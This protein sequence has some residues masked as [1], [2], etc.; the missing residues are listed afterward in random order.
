[1][2]VYPSG[3]DLSTSTLRYLADLLRARRRERG[4]RWRRLTADRQALLALAH[5]R[6][7][8]TY[9]QLA[10]G[11]GIGLATV[12][13][14][15]V[16]AIEVLAALAPTLQ[17]VITVAAN[18]AFV[19]LDGTLLHIDRIAADRP[20][21]SGKHKR[22][23]MN[24]QVIADAFGRLLW[25]S[26]ALPG[27]VHDIKAARTHGIVEALT[28]AGIRTWADKGYQGAQGTIRVPYQG[29]WRTLP[30]GKRAVNSSHARIRAVGEQ[31]NA[32]RKSWR[33]LRKL[34]CS[35]TRITDIVKAVLAL[36]LATA[37]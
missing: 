10:V 36:H 37:A 26:P 29:R 24:V 32:T 18:K 6:G 20:Y 30:A 7:G 1:M 35:T 22:H 27:A 15:I 21:Y 14:Y 33:L 13:R 12:Y 11:F 25:A 31:A 28:R 8:H 4:T 9:A 23:G 16:E 3:I 2:L 34:R 5:L 19:I 17:Q